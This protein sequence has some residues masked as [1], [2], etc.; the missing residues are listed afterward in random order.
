MKVIFVGDKP[1]SKNLDPNVPFIGTPSYKTLLQWIEFLE[2]KDYEL[3]N[4][5]SDED[6]DYIQEKL[7]DHIF[8]ALGN[9]AAKVLEDEVLVYFKLPHP[10]PK[11]RK[12]N[13]KNYLNEILT[14]CKTFIHEKNYVEKYENYAVIEYYNNVGAHHR[15]DG[16]AIE[17][18]DGD[19]YWYINNKR[20]RLDGPAVEWS[21]GTKYWYI[22][23]NNYTEQ[24]FQQYIKM[25]EA[26]KLLGLND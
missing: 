3:V 4:S 14:K 15:L 2:V 13:N 20:H 16:P 23:D 12:L 5:F 21:D 7:S 9:N 10:S 17:Y 24:E 11:N 25:L 6:K 19:K 8:I 18:S 1:S 26:K 22:N